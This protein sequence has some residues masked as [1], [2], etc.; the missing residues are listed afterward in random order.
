LAFL[1]EFPSLGVFR[2]PGDLPLADPFFFA[3]TLVTVS[4]TAVPVVSGFVEPVTEVATVSEAFVFP[5]VGAVLVISVFVTVESPA[6]NV[7]GF[8]VVAVI[9][10]VFVA[11]PSTPV[12]VVL[13]FVSVVVFVEAASIAVPVVALS[14]LATVV[15]ATLVDLFVCAAVV[16]PSSVL[17]TAVP[18]SFFV[19]GAAVV[20]IVPAPSGRVA[21]VTGGTA[22]TVTFGLSVFTSVTS[23]LIVVV[24]APCFLRLNGPVC[25]SILLPDF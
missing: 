4:L 23:V 25:I 10:L 1:V 21:T 14:G 24:A 20:L 3:G 8:V 16:P 19:T 18:F 9:S 13:A 6:V 22:A 7:S 11:V 5:A 2:V 12:G 15:F 17:V